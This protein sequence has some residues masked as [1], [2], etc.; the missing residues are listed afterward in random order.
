MAKNELTNEDIFASIAIQR[1]ELRNSELTE[2]QPAHIPQRILPLCRDK[3]RCSFTPTANVHS[4]DQ[5]TKEL[6]RYRR[7][8]AKFMRNL[9]PAME[10]TVETVNL[11]KFFWRQET[12]QDRQ[13]FSY[14]LQG[15][16]EWE[17]IT[18][19]HYGEPLGKAVTYYRCKF[20]VK[21]SQLK[22]GVAFLCFDGV[23][24]K[25]HVFVNNALVGSHEGFFAPFEF[26]ISNHIHKGVNTLLVKVENDAVQ[27]GNNFA[28]NHVEGDK[29]YAA[30]GCGYD[31]PQLGWH[32]CPPGMGIYQPVRLKLRSRVFIKDIFVRPILEDN[33]AELWLEI[34]NCNTTE[35]RI[36]LEISVFGQNFR[37]TV[38][39]NTLVIPHTTQIR[40][41]GDVEQ[42]NKP[43]VENLMGPG[44]NYLRVPLI[45]HNP[46]LWELSSPWLYQVQV[47]LLDNNNSNRG[48]NGNNAKPNR[49]LD[50]ACQQFGMR[51]FIQDETTTPKG[52]F[53]LNGKEIRLRGANTMGHLQRCVMENN[54][55][56]L[57]DDILL[58]KICNMNFL[59]FTQR[60]VQKQIYEMCD[61]LGIMNQ[62][63]LPLFGVLRRNKIIE[64]V[65]QAGEMEQLIRAHPS[66]VIISYINEPYPNATGKP[67][68]FLVRHELEEF[69]DIASKIVHQ[70]NPDR[71]IKYCDGDYDPPARDGMPDNHCYCGWYIGHGLDLGK[72]HRGYW[73]AVK[74]NWHYGCGEFGAEGLDNY[75]VMKKYYPREWLP[76]RC[77]EKSLWSPEKIAYAQTGKFHYLWY[78]TPKTIEQWIQTSQDHQAWITKLMTEAFRRD[79]RM[80]SFAIHLFIDAWPAGWMKTIMDVQRQPKK[81][82]YAYR[83]ALTPLMVSLRSDR[84]SFW[85][86]EKMQ[87]EAWICNDNNGAPKGCYLHYQLEHRGKIIQAGKAKADIPCCSSKPQGYIKFTIPHTDTRCEITVRMALINKQSQILHETYENFKVFPFSQTTPGSSSNIGGSNSKPNI[88]GNGNSDKR[89]VIVLADKKTLLCQFADEMGVRYLH[90]KTLQDSSLSPDSILLIG[91][92]NMYSRYRKIIDTAVSRGSL[93]LFLEMPIGKYNIAGDIVEILPAGMGPRHFVARDKNHPLVQDFRADDFKFWYDKSVGYPT[94]IL[95]TVISLPEKD[96]AI[97]WENILISGNGNWKGGWAM[98]PAA[99]EKKLGR[100][101]LRICQLK[102]VHRMQHN[103]AAMMFAQK[104]VFHNPS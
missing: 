20:N 52:K 92:P 25:A 43:D 102:L 18:I 80:N 39:K 66:S 49:L 42:F 48:S 31:D 68:R 62:T 17:C 36:A 51:S 67:H 104:L 21:A 47:R 93:A 29:I 45:I 9:A 50:T 99:I 27:M 103:P 3:S 70:L 35:Q 41:H 75:N 65:K 14:T 10:K 83:D 89:T 94:P 54:P 11:N 53:Y 78:E 7:L 82:Y 69:F 63:D 61:K 12:Q 74:Q 15:L 19:P 87:L 90:K 6:V 44:I 23:D 22:K 2:P 77:R 97:S 76:E 64:A 38:I 4:S 34:Y 28:G 96:A 58:A 79:S 72:L 13:D 88:N 57:R 84:N 32:H 24:Y 86:G 40:G 5:L 37:K 8:Y 46:R 60:P 55:E 30:S 81:A 98:V 16:G 91:H 85:A 56:Q 59:R 95:N 101:V 71:V 73:I 26:E 1:L 100:G 33:T